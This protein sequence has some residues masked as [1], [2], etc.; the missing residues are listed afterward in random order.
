MAERA[1][2]MAERFVGALNPKEREILDRRL[3]GQ[4]LRA[5]EWARQRVASLRRANEK[6]TALP[7][8]DRMRVARELAGL[9]RGQV[10]KF[11]QLEP[12]IVATIEAGETK[13]TPEQ[14]AALADVY[15]VPIGWL[16]GE[17]APEWLHL[18]LMFRLEH[19]NKKAS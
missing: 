7:V 17:R 11:L 18:L 3:G 10:A 8:V 9:T 14:L 6:A 16:Q 15:D 12:S 1:A 2:S 5:K 19:D 4:H 13:T